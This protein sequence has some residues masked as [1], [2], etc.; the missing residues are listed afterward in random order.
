[1]AWFAAVAVP[2]VTGPT[3]VPPV[4]TSSVVADIFVA[5][6]VSVVLFQL[7][8]TECASAAVPFPY[9]TFPEET[10]LLPV[11]PDATESAGDNDVAPVTDKLPEITWFVQVSVVVDESYTSPGLDETLDWLFPKGIRPAGK[12]AIPVPPELTDNGVVN[13]AIPDEILTHVTL[14][15]VNEVS[16]IVMGVLLLYEAIV[17]Q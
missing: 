3:N 15:G 11:P 16:K 4:D 10:E 1:M 7:N 17:S 5:D 13:D 8:A 12:E 9:K 2:T 14:L 6:R